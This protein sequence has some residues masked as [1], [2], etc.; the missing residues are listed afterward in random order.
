[1]LRKDDFHLKLSYLLTFWAHNWNQDPCLSTE[2]SIIMR[3]VCLLVLLA[4][5]YNV[6]H[7]AVCELLPP[8]DGASEEPEF[9][10]IFVPGA[11]IAGEAYRY[12][13]FHDRTL[14]VK[15]F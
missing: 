12:S 9:G 10:V 2:P 1:M 5:G 3:G 15:A 8:L 14:S 6:S 7:A 13:G 4:F 11:D